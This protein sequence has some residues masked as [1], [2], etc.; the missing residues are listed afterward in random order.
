MAIKFLITGRRWLIAWLAAMF[1]AVGKSSLELCDLLT[2]SLGKSAKSESICWAT[3]TITSLTFMFVW[4]PEPVWKTRRGKSCIKVAS[5][6]ANNWSLAFWINRVF[7]VGNNPNRLFTPAAAFLTLINAR[8]TS[9]GING[10]VAKLCRLR[11]VCAPHKACWGTF[12]F[13]N[14]SSSIR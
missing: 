14:V 1:I 4:V 7:S 5:S 13:P 10:P 3:C 12:T 8:I 6:K 2:S 9:T 11:S